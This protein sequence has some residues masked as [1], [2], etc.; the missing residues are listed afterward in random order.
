LPVMSQWEA[1]P[2][3]RVGASALGYHVIAGGRVLPRNGG[4]R[5]LRHLA[6]PQ[7][8]RDPHL[9]LRHPCHNTL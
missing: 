4:K 6:S 5:L 2:R 3:H 7:S 1:P 8:S 9:L